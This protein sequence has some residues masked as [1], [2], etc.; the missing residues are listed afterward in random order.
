M[1]FL[2]SGGSTPA[3]EGAAAFYQDTTYLPYG[4]S[5]EFEVEAGDLS[6]GNV[7]VVFATKGDG[8]GALFAQAYP[9]AWRAINYGPTS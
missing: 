1:R 6:G 9:L 3:V 7:T 4:V 8:G 2:S 5:F